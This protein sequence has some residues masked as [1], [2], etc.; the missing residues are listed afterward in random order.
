[1]TSSR[2]EPATLRLIAQCLS[3][4]KQPCSTQLFDF[5]NVSNEIINRPYRACEFSGI[6]WTT[7]HALNIWDYKKKGVLKH[8]H[9]RVIFLYTCFISLHMYCQWPP[10]PPTTH[11][12][13]TF[14]NG[15]SSRYSAVQS[16]PQTIKPLRNGLEMLSLTQWNYYRRNLGR[17]Y[18]TIVVSICINVI[19][20]KMQNLRHS[21]IWAVGTTILLY[22]YA[23]NVI[24]KRTQKWRH[25]CKYYRIMVAISLFVLM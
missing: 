11:P 6:Y 12:T 5:I 3:Q 19:H 9:T 7:V 23:I 13:M 18:N 17:R 8:V 4:L 14:R 16:S 22:R 24:H 21:D 25:V 1:M 2:M 20:K 15:N 10:P